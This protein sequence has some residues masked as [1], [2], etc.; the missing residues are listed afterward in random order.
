MRITSTGDVQFFRNGVSNEVVS[1]SN[2]IDG[3]R[4]TIKDELDNIVGNLIPDNSGTGGRLVLSRDGANT[5]FDLNGNWGGTGDPNLAMYSSTSSAQINLSVTGNASVQLPNDG[6]ANHEI[7]NE[8]GTVND[9]EQTGVVMPQGSYTTLLSRT[10]VAPTS[11]YAFVIASG[12]VIVGLGEGEGST[13]ADFGVSDSGTIPPGASMSIQIAPGYTDQMILPVTV[14]AFFEVAAGNNTFYFKGFTLSENSH[15][16]FS[17]QDRQMTVIFLPT[18]YG[19]VEPTTATGTSGPPDT[20]ITTG[21]ALTE[22]DLAAEKAA[23][24]ADN[25]AR[26]QRE[27][28][29][30]RER[31]RQLEEERDRE[32]G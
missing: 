32:N 10:L 31:L 20:Q 14:H 21:D 1:V 5:G 12:E 23:S 29:E 13:A 22:A 8:A 6:I 2:D 16:G 25:L 17:V 26:I 11:G 27:M 4:V 19:T 28:D 3:G 15:G 30:M 24:Q 9:F 7:L 18:A